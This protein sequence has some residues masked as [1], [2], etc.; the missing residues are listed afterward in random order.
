VFSRIVSSLLGFAS[1]STDRKNRAPASP[2]CV[3]ALEK[4]VLF[5]AVATSIFSDN[6][7]EVQV[8][9]SAPLDPATVNT[10]SVFVFTPGANGLFGDGDDTK[11]VGRV[12]LRNGNRR[13][14]FVPDQ[15]VPFIAGSSYGFKLNSTRMKSAD[16]HRIDGEFNGGGLATGNGTEG[17]DLLVISKKNKTN[18]IARFSTIAGNIDVR[19]FLAQTPKNVA[20]F[21]TYTNDGLWDNTFV[22]R[23]IPGFIW[24]S[25]GFTVTP[26]N[27][28]D[29]VVALTPA[30]NEPAATHATRG[31]LSLARPDDNDPATDDKGSNQFFFNLADNRG[32]PPNGLDFQN[33]GFTEFGEVINAGG[34]AVMDALAAFST[35]NGGGPFTNLAVQ[36]PGTTVEQVG[37][38]PQGT[39][40]TIRRIALRN[41]VVAWPT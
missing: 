19:L 11:V 40:V 24:Q 27:Q 38:D 18:I 5:H 16:G 33:G 22:Q 17:G 14:L 15:K 31:T 2:A 30:D 37:A 41:T 7:G 39:L 12:K 23:N 21:I 10:R 25:G 3:D 36:Q 35:V 29:D 20:N 13:V 9:F 26:D 4:R 32:T 34:L 6:R 28:I 8:T 1:I